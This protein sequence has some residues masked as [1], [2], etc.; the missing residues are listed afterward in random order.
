MQTARQVTSFLALVALGLCV[1]PASA[2]PDVRSAKLPIPLPAKPGQAPGVWGLELAGDAQAT[3]NRAEDGSVSITISAVDSTDYHVRLARA[4][5]SLI[6]GK[7]Y[8]VSF[9][10]KADQPRVIKVYGQTDHNDFHGIG[11]DIPVQLRGQWSDYKFSFKATGV[12]PK[13]VRCPQFLLGSQTGI[14]SLADILLKEAP[15][16]TVLMGAFP[17]PP[18]AGLSWEFRNFDPSVGSLR[19]EGTAQVVTTASTDGTA[20]HVQLNRLNSVLT[21]GQ[22]VTV[23]F[24]ARAAASTDLLVSG[25][26]VGGDYHG[27]VKDTWEAVGKD[28]QDYSLVVTPHDI[29]GRPVLFPQFLLGHTPG[30]VWI[31]RVTTSTDDLS[32]SPATLS[33]SSAQPALPTELPGVGEIRLEGTVR[34]TRFADGSFVLLVMRTMEPSGAKQDLSEPRPKTV[35]LNK[36]TRLGTGLARLVKLSTVLHTGDTVAVIGRNLGSGKVLPARQILTV[37]KAN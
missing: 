27:I 20:W 9:R 11:L 29:G 3:L 28:W 12:E 7:I 15:P 13:H 6:E 5:V 17:P 25:Q 10:A 22:P 18:P 23:R 2:A 1:L 14:V 34:E 35:V 32:K 37:P 16:G 36:K 4:P 30:T 21:E 8:T 24:R 31:D 19:Q 33:G 26:V